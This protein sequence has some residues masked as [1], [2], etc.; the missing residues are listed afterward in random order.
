MEKHRPGILLFESVDTMDSVQH[1]SKHGM[2]NNMDLVCAEW[3][4]RGYE[5]QKRHVNTRIFSPPQKR[6]RLLVV[7]VLTVSNHSVCFAKRSTGASFDTLRALLKV[8]VREC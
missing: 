8:C 1:D 6:R 5:T 4:A 3:A 2:F 7:V